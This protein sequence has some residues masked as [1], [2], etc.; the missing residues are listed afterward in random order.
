MHNK[1]IHHFGKNGF[2]LIEA[3]IA[4]GIVALVATASVALS[5]TILHNSSTS[6]DQLVASRLASQAIEAARWIRD[7]NL[8]DGD[9][10]TTWNYLST[11][12]PGQTDQ[13]ASLPCD[14]CDIL[15]SSLV[16]LETTTAP[17]F[18]YTTSPAPIIIQSG[19]GVTRTYYRQMKIKKDATDADNILDIEVVVSKNNDYSDPLADIATQLTNWKGIK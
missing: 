14:N 17:S 9:V 7:R 10:T 2:G 1:N 18:Y 15:P 16:A 13:T 5:T 12:Q 11:N 4:S 3:L 8:S 19:T 6:Y